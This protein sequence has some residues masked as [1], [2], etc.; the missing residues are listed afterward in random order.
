M[1]VGKVGPRGGVRERPEQR[2]GRGYFLSSDRF[3]VRR[4]SERD[5]RQIKDTTDEGAGHARE[6]ELD[7]ARA[8]QRLLKK[9]KKG[10]RRGSLKE[11][12]ESGIGIWKTHHRF[13]VVNPVRERLRE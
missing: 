12:V 4:E 8:K 2:E 7:S 5:A 1:I 3:E 6:K 10:M 11:V 13:K 9:I